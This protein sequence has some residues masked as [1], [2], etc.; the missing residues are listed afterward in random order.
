MKPV[1][2]FLPGFRLALYVTIIKS[3]PMT[4]MQLPV[5]IDIHPNSNIAEIDI[6]LG[7]IFSC[8]LPNINFVAVLFTCAKN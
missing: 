3:I 2:E 1:S 6:P 5:R 8:N 7:K 4:A